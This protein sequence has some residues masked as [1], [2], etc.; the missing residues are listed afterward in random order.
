MPQKPRPRIPRNVIVV[1]FVALASGFG[2][3]LITPILPG[4][5]TL[6]GIGA[7]GIGFIDERVSIRLRIPL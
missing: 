6:L 5:L 7:A 3:D 4:F 2:Q 1:A